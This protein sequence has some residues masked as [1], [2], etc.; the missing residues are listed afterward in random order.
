MAIKNRRDRIVGAVVYGGVMAYIAKNIPCKRRKDLEVD[1][2]EGM[3]LE[4]NV[5]NDK[6]F[7]L[8]VYRA[9]SNTDEIFWQ[10][11]QDMINEVQSN[12]NAKIMIIGDLNADPHTRHGQ[13][14]NE[15][16]FVNDLKQ[17]ITKPTRI[18]NTSETILD[19]ILTNFYSLVKHVSIEAPITSSD[20]CLIGIS[21]SFKITKKKAYV[22]RM[23]DFSKADFDLYRQNLN[24]VNWENIFMDQN[25]NVICDRFTENVFLAAQNAIPNKLVTV[26]PADKPWYNDIS[27]NYIDRKIDYIKNTRQPKQIY[28]GLDSPP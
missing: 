26:R 19:Q 23:W 22:R 16:A 21:C 3:W 12:N 4:I 28:V 20:H 25:I 11:M 1:H 10:V 18:T 8:V 24:K 14:L 5:I 6:F 7:L 9:E 27:E 15:F 2:I 17:H 13:L